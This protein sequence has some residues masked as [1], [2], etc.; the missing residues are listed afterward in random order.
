MFPSLDGAFELWKAS[1]CAHDS[2]CGKKDQRGRHRFS[3]FRRLW[4]RLRIGI[5][6]LNSFISSLTSAHRLVVTVLALVVIAVLAGSMISAATPL[7]VGG[8]VCAVLLLLKP[9][10]LPAG[11]GGTRVRI[12]A[13]TGAFAAAGSYGYWPQIVDA[14][15]ALLSRNEDVL[16]V[17]PWIQNIKL[18]AVPSALA[19][20]FLLG[21]IWLV[22]RSLGP[23]QIGGRH[24]TPLEKEFL[25]KTFPQ[26]LDAF[27]SALRD[28]LVTVD[29]DTNWSPEYY[30][31]LEAEVEIQ[32]AAGGRQRR[33]VVDLQT[34][35]RSDRHSRVFLVLGDP[36]SGKSV[37][38]RKLAQDMLSEVHKSQRVPIYINLR[39]WLRRH[40]RSNEMAAPRTG[41]EDEKPSVAELEQFVRRSVKARGDVFTEDFVDRYFRDLWD[42]GYLF[43]I[44]DSFDEIPELLDVEEESSVIKSLSETVSRFIATN[45]N[46]RGVLASRMFR[47]PTQDFLAE[48][49]LE[50]RPL[51]EERIS[52]ALERFPFFSESTKLEL[53]R[54]H[55]DL[56]SIARNPFLMALLGTWVEDHRTFPQSQTQLYESYL[57]GRLAK[58]RSRMQEHGLTEDA[59]IKGAVDIA[60]FV[61]QS[62]EYGLEAPIRVLGDKSITPRAYPVI[63]VLQFARIARVTQAEPK[64]FAFVHRRFL[65]YMVTSKFIEDPGLV[66]SEHIPT[67]SRG[68]DSLVL[69]AQICAEPAAEALA[70]RC[71]SE[72]HTHFGDPVS[73][74][75]AIHSL[76]FLIDAFQSRRNVLAG[77]QQELA[78]LISRH[79]EGNNVILSKVSLESTGL[80]PEDAADAVLRDAITG[81][82]LWLQET[83]FR[84]C[85]HL[86]R[87]NP[88][89][90]ESATRY[91][92]FMPGLH[93]WTTSRALIFSLSLSDALSAVRR[94]AVLR[95]RNMI[96]SLCASPVAFILA[97]FASSVTLAYLLTIVLVGR[98]LLLNDGRSAKAKASLARRVQFLDE[99]LI[100]SLVGFAV[101]SVALLSTID[102]PSLEV[103]RDLGRLLMVPPWSSTPMM[104]N[105]AIAAAAISGLALVDWQ[106]FRLLLGSFIRSLMRLKLADIGWISG[107]VAFAAVVFGFVWLAERLGVTHIIGWVFGVLMG[108]VGTY[109]TVLALRDLVHWS[110]ECRAVRRRKLSD[111]MS[112]QEIAEMFTSLKFNGARLRF[113]NELARRRVKAK[114]DWP[115]DF[116]LVAS[117]D[118]SIN[119]L[120]KLEERW[121]G[122]DR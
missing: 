12:L 5:A 108:V 96:V 13:L 14:I 46:S 77:I 55:P 40:P 119:A 88:Q 120:A 95:R 65:E 56:A 41:G 62:Q 11:W 84:A 6:V 118:A 92:I 122:L 33:T 102:R 37:A 69:Y 67:D 117:S 116:Q 80:L 115:A 86:P 16:A 66:P 38:L 81:K 32:P 18:G 10:L 90:I 29:R 19:L 44:F 31:R 1:A 53:F 112:R 58:S 113:V 52:H 78:G 79:A 57:R 27:C 22:L 8:V 101:T 35:I 103:S 23:E 48:K 50:I 28:H 109:G 82:D 7:I 39:E 89:L 114:G 93:F 26:K 64:S 25:E 106:R 68:R 105:V 76:R 51:S 2:S 20:L 3:S 85:R 59:V 104:Q 34:A 54:N 75:R 73:R 24:P 87:P 100:R 61:F 60:W 43:F 91:V 72:I 121:L 99:G 98:L 36:G 21:V 42:H 97:P 15:V 47:R 70:L 9:L 17:A 63:D 83:A 110:K 45:P 111:S 94:V 4:T 74:L 49:I 30:T 71:W 107:I